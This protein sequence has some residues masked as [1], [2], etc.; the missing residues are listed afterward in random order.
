MTAADLC[1]GA[2]RELRRRRANKSTLP[3][4]P[5]LKVHHA[6]GRQFTINNEHAPKVDFDREYFNVGGYF[7]EY[8]PSIFA[9]APQLLAALVQLVDHISD[10]NNAG[11]TMLSVTRDRPMQDARRIIREATEAA[12]GIA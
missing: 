4:I 9:T 6:G 10:P 8:A 7:G 5:P 3:T 1:K 2:A 11:R 12:N